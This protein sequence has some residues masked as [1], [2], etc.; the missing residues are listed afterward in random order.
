MPAN[1]SFPILL[2]SINIFSSFHLSFV[3]NYLKNFEVLSHTISYFT[4]FKVKQ[5]S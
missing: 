4:I 5:N 2:F 1:D 3:S